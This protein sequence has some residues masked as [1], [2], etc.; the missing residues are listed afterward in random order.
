MSASSTTSAHGYKFGRLKEAFHYSKAVAS[1][2]FHDLFLDSFPPSAYR[3]RVPSAMPE[4]S[5]ISC[6]VAEGNGPAEATTTGSGN[7]LIIWC[8]FPP[9]SR[10]T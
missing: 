10:G 7:S 6:R 8:Q 1:L 4:L 9:G 3:Y 2:R 5:R